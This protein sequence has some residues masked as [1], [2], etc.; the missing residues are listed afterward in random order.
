M[1]ILSN[2]PMRLHTTFKLGGP[3]DFFCI[4][5]I[6]EEILS[7]VDLCIKYNIPLTVIGNGSNLI[8]RD[9]GVTGLVMKIADN[10]DDCFVSGNK[11]RAQAGILIDD[12]IQIS[13]D[14]DLEGLECMAGV[15]AALGG[16]I[17]MN[18]GYL[19]SIGKL[20][21]WVR[22]VD[23]KTG[24]QFVL[25][26]KDLD[27][28]YRT[29]IFH[30]QPMIIL[31]AEILLELGN[32]KKVAKT[33][34]QYKLR[35]QRQQPIDYPSCGSVFKKADLRPYAGLSIGDAEVSTLC[36]A[37][38]INNG[39]ATAEDVLNLIDEINSR[40]I[41]PFTLEARVL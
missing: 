30:K 37:Y 32:G 39:N 25:E 28:G 26:N 41:K 9:V 38:I 8:V 33:I 13:I 19:G 29:S 2:E 34:E 21:N 14:N 23:Y 27:F 7:V 16:A 18:A 1:E 20:I 36:P 22:A 11:I 4:P 40:N 10:F 6:E 31:E 35:R 17:F 24:Q 5:Y 15:P 3:A 12:L